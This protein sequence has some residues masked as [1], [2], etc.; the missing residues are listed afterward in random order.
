MKKNGTCDFRRKS[1]TFADAVKRA[2]WRDKNGEEK[3]GIK[4]IHPEKCFTKNG[5]FPNIG[6][7]QYYHYNKL[8]IYKYD[9]ITESIA[10]VWINNDEMFINECP[11]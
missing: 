4:Y 10:K 2:D 1:Q 8:D 5:L 7:K 3:Y 6:I 11:L 9:G